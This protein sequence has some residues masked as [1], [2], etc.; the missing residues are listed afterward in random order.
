MP[1][2]GELPGATREAVIEA[3]KRAQLDDYVRTLPDGYDTQVGE[4]GAKLS[5]GS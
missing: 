5:G 4:R 3:A 2:A 1:V